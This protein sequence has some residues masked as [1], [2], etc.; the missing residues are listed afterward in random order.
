MNMEVSG[1]KILLSQNIDQGSCNGSRKEWTGLYCIQNELGKQKRKIA[2][3]KLFKK[4][5]ES[6]QNLMPC[7]MMSPL[8]V[9]QY[10]PI[11]QSPLFDLVIID[12]ASQLKPE[13][14][15]SAIIRGSQLLV[16]GDSKQLP[17]TCFFG[18]VL[19]DEDIDDEEAI[20]NESILDMAKAMF[21]SHSLRWHYRSKHDS[22]IYFSNQQFYDGRLIV[23]PSSRG[24]SQLVGVHLFQANGLYKN[25]ENLEEANLVIEKAIMCMKVAPKES[26][27]IVVMNRQQQELIKSLLY[28]VRN[29]NS[30]VDSY[31]EYWEEKNE[32]CFVK[33]LENVQGDERDIIIISTVY[34]PIERGSK[35]LRRFGPINS[36]YGHR[37]LNVLCTRAKSCMYV[38]TS[39]QPSD[40]LPSDE[41]ISSKGIDAFS[42]FLDFAGSG[43]LLTKQVSQEPESPFEE[44]VGQFLSDAGYDVDYQIGQAGFRI[45][46]GLRHPAYPYGFLAGIECDGAT[47]HS[48]RT[49]RDRDRLRQEILENHGWKIYRIWSTDWFYSPEKEKEKL[50]NWISTRIAELCKKYSSEMN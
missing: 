5:L 23:C 7:F 22:L 43:Q 31:L 26:I 38:I 44:Y 17:P 13:E 9:A 40:I 16:V 11:S 1:Q 19:E 3:R 4:S 12:E 29:T 18:T 45:D 35:V 25:G 34:G 47:Y 42:K 8:S 27:G 50:L 15:F 46:I 6:L 36:I 21:S 2:P 28:Q 41:T 39:L 30:D 49:A 32:H 48:H 10:L 33:N 37:R 24:V 14:A 20:D